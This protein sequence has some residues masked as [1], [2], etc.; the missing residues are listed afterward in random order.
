MMADRIL[1]DYDRMAGDDP[2]DMD[3]LLVTLRRF[4]TQIAR[5]EARDMRTRLI[6]SCAA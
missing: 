3:D 1:H 4:A 5:D 6:S 2:D